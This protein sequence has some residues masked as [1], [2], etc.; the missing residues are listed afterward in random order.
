[1]GIVTSSPSYYAKLVLDH[2]SIEYDTLTAYHDTKRNKP[3]PEP[4]LKGVSSLNLDVIQC[5]SIGDTI[6]DATASKKAGVRFI[7]ALWDC[8]PNEKDELIS[9]SD[10]SCE[11]P[12]ELNNLL[13]KYFS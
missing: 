6:S 7:S 9:L 10:F 1:M 8:E 5:L 11:T 13:Q 12:S 4:I 3:H 2:F